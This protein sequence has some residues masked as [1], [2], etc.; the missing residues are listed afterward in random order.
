MR[1]CEL[2]ITKERQAVP[3]VLEYEARYFPAKSPTPRLA[4]LV[5]VGDRLER[6]PIDIPRVGAGRILVRLRGAYTAHDGE[7]FESIEGM[8]AEVFVVSRGFQFALWWGDPEDIGPNEPRFVEFL[9]GSVNSRLHFAAVFE[10]E[11]GHINKY[12][13]DCPGRESALI[14]LVEEIR[15]EV[16]GRSNLPVGH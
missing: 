8:Y 5:Q 10:R 6:V 2:E 14:E 11:L 15:T 7:V 3:Y 9:A 13:I 4:R 16:A 1:A 12:G